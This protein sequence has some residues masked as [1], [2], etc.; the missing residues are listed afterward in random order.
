[1]S[2]S[3]RDLSTQKPCCM[4]LRTMTAL[5]ATLVLPAVAAQRATRRGHRQHLDLAGRKRLD[6]R[7]HTDRPFLCQRSASGLDLADHW[8]PTSWSTSATRCG[9][10]VSSGSLSIWRSRSI[11]RP[12]LS[13]VVPNPLRPA[14]CRRPARQFLADERHRRYQKRPDPQPRRGRP[15]CGRGTVAERLSQPHR[16]GAQPMAGA[17]RSRTPRRSRCCMNAPGA[18]RWEPS[19]DWKPM[20]CR[21]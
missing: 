9:A 12:T 2:G 21:R 10:T 18:C 4:N 6:L 15:G 5:A 13:C 3:L 16:P 14:L 17:A 7:R 19:R 8:F 1:M 11:P 20:R